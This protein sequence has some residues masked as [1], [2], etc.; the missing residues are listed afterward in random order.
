MDNKIDITKLKIGDKVRYQ[1]IYTDGNEWENGRIKEIR[2]GTS[3][4]VWVVYNCGGNWDKYKDYTGAK[5]RLID[6]KIGWLEVVK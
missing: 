2:E 6:L 4:A 3:N 1:P 5:T